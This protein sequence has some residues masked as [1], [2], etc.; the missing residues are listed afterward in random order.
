LQNLKSLGNGAAAKLTQAM[1]QGDL[2]KAAEEIE[3]LAKEL[4]DGKFDAKTKAELAKQLDEMKQKLADAAIAHQEAMERE[5]KQ[6]EQERQQGDL[7]KAGEQQQKLDELAAQSPQ[8]Q[9]LE[10]LANQMGKMQQSLIQGDS[11]QAANAMQQMAQQLQKM[12]QQVSEAQMLDEA[13][14]QLQ[15]A[16]EAMACQNC[17]G[18]GCEKCQ[19]ESDN[20][21][22]MKSAQP[23]D[24]RPASG[25]GK[26]TGNGRAPQNERDTSTRDV[27]VRQQPGQGPAV[28]AGKVDGPNVKGDV[29]ATI[30]AEVATFGKSSSDPL[31]NERLPRNRREHAEE[32]FNL[33]RDGK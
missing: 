2:Q 11:Q 8:M 28:Y 12:Q 4:R 23:S 27:Q 14:D 15:M 13:M 21:V 9:H 10:Q 22:A 33:L 18:A 31:I 32:Y 30:Q 7:A 26:G 20:A 17:K 25:I 5:Q 16:K 3:K 1:K 29:A 19:G 6:I 24:G